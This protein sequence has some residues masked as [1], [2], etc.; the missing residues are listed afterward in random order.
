MQP[1]RGSL[2]DSESRFDDAPPGP[3]RAGPGFPAEQYANP[4]VRH[5]PRQIAAA[6]IGVDRRHGAP[7]RTQVCTEA[8]A[9]AAFESDV[10]MKRYT[11]DA[12]WTLAG[13]LFG[14]LQN[15][16]ASGRNLCQ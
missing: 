4:H 10:S 7:A 15:T 13:L 3:G 14:R 5:N 6:E 12:G 2:A 11:E 8:L 1:V 16:V 9:N